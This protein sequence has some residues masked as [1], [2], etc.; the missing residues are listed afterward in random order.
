MVCGN[1]SCDESAHGK[2]VR[3]YPL[4]GRR[5]AT[6]SLLREGCDGRLVG[7]RH[8]TGLLMRKGGAG[9]Q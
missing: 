3:P 1:T 9:T 2:G 7:N 8:V 4:V 5:H 6:G